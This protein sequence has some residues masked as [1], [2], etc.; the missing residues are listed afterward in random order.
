[1][2]NMIT[3]VSAED[4]ER[5]TQLVSDWMLG[6]PTAE[7]TGRSVIRSLLDPLILIRGAIVPV[8][9]E[10]DTADPD[11]PLDMESDYG[12]VAGSSGSF[13]FSSVDG[14]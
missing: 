14:D 2:F 9:S 6:L 3:N 12:G 1:M 4:Y 10:E 11:V 5:F 8:T 7:I 13:L